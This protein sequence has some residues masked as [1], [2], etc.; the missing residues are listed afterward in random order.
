VHNYSSRVAS[1]LTVITLGTAIALS[2]ERAPIQENEPPNTHWYKGNLHTHSLWSDGDDFPDSIVARYK[3]LGYHFLALTDH[4]ILSEKQRYIATQTLAP[5][6]LAKYKTTFGPS[7]VETRTIKGEQQ[8]RLKPLRELRSLFDEP[9]RFLLIQ[10][11]EITDR[12]LDA[13]GTSYP[14][15]L[16]ATNLRDLILPQGG[17]SVSQTIQNNVQAVEEQRAATERPMIVHL[18][19]PNFGW[20]VTAEDLL[21]DENGMFFEVYNGH[22]SVRNYG[23]PSHANTERIWDIVLT[24]RIAEQNGSP[25]FGIATDD[26]HNYHE[27]SSLKSNPGRGWIVVRASHLTAESIIH[28]MEEGDFYCSTGVTLKDIRFD[29]KT[30]QIEIQPENGVSYHTEFIG[31]R[32]D[33]DA[34]SSVVVDADGKPLH[35]TRR[36]SNE[37]GMVLKKTKGLLPS[38]DLQGNELYIRARIRS[39]KHQPNPFEEGDRERAWTQPVFP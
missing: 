14:V 36:Y 2:F 17:N 35:A 3:R 4:N 39:T 32:R 25:L 30:L 22:P 23:D 8:V 33:F 1:V 27:F 15:H 5:G 37:I 28:A 29:G 19:H 10:G 24:R 16:N 7:W 26:S 21:P 6:A 18:N 13:N 11:E 20:G 31:T 9:D 34:D 12:F 38:Y